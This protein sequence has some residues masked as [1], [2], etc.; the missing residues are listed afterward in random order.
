MISYV[1]NWVLSNVIFISCIN[2]QRRVE[3]FPDLPRRELFRARKK[4]AYSF[5]SFIQPSERIIL[6]C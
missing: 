6:I 3:K 1:Q 2:L 4:L 5:S